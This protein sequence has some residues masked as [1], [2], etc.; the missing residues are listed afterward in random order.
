[1]NDKRAMPL[2]SIILFTSAILLT[3][4]HQSNQED[5]KSHHM[6]ALNLVEKSKGF[7][8]AFEARDVDKMKSYF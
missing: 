3:S 5:F 8:E 2:W 7:I 4:C 1:M 6:D